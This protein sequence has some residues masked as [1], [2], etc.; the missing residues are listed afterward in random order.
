MAIV[1]DNARNEADFEQIL[2]LQSANLPEVV[3]KEDV[4]TQGF[5]TLRHDVALLKK[6]NEPY[7]HIVAR[8]EEKIVGYALI[9]LRKFEEGIPDLA[10]MF[11]R[12]NIRSYQGLPLD[13]ANY[14]IMGQ[15]CVEHAYRGQGLFRSLYETMRA[16][17][18]P[19][20]DYMITEVSQSNLRSRK[21]HLQVGCQILE[22]YTSEF[23]GK[24]WTIFIWDWH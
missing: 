3:A 1:Y 12:I 14:F 16:Q 13:K 17:L 24:G 23:D 19:H 22:E 11:E 5:V 7:P 10:P 2:I 20:F 18:A 6:M 8:D 4:S 15:V 21:A 9:M